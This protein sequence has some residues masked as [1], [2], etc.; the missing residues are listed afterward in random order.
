MEFVTQDLP[1][2]EAA[3]KRRKAAKAT[4][5]TRNSSKGKKTGKQKESG[6][7][8]RGFNLS[9]YKPHALADYTNTI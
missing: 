9:S 6:P 3:R 8:F 4:L 2:E 7:R 1:S 5:K